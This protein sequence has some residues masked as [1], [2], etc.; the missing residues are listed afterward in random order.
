MCVGY[1]ERLGDGGCCLGSPRLGGSL[2]RQESGCFGSHAW[3]MDPSKCDLVFKRFS[4][5][6]HIIKESSCI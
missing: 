5:A 6:F 1:L 2:S 3:K 4:N